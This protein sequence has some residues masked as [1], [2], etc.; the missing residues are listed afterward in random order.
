MQFAK[1][2]NLVSELRATDKDWISAFCHKMSAVKIFSLVW[3]GWHSTDGFAHYYSAMKKDFP[4]S[5]LLLW[6]LLQSLPTWSNKKKHF[7]HATVHAFHVIC[8]PIYSISSELHAV[9]IHIVFVVLHC[10]GWFE[11]IQT[12]I[13]GHWVSKC[14]VFTNQTAQIAR[15]ASSAWLIFLQL[16]NTPA[17]IC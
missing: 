11:G 10:F 5:K 17:F 4:P 6:L 1:L 8:R 3:P 9:I 16:A 14:C 12:L 15:S 7:Y 2:A 13:C